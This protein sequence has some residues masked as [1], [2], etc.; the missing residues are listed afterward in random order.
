MDE[1]NHMSSGDGDS[2][3]G[4]GDFELDDINVGESAS[5]HSN[6]SHRPSRAGSTTSSVKS[7]ASSAHIKARAEKAALEAE[8]KALEEQNALELET[9][10]VQMEIQQCQLKLE[11][12]RREIELKVKYA[13]AD[14]LA[15][16]Y[17]EA[18]DA[19]SEVCFNPNP[20]L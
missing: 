1:Y 14:A 4:H 13:R 15:K 18:E 16:T 8:A 2:P 7:S 20:T 11:Q 10:Q 3:D 19:S 6:R 12:R 5:Q 17:A 9:L